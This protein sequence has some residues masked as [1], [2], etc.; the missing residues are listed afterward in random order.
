MY[1]AIRLDQLVEKALTVRDQADKFV[2]EAQWLIDNPG[3]PNVPGVYAVP[4]AQEGCLNLF[5]RVQVK[6]KPYCV[7]KECT[8]CKTCPSDLEFVKEAY[9]VSKA[10]YLGDFPKELK[11]KINEDIPLDYEHPTGADFEKLLKN[12]WLC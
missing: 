8:G 3:A 1:D 12:V 7:W 10:T 2:Q 11:G 4:K 6:D 9:R 5:W